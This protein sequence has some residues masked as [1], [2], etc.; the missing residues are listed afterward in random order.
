M[1][2]DLPVILVTGATGKLGTLVIEKLLKTVPAG[3]IVAGVRDTAAAAA[4]AARGVHVRVLD[5]DR[6]ETLDAAFAGVDRVLL[7]SSNAVD[8]RL[9]QHVNVVV[10]AART[11]VSLLAYTSIL[12]ADTSPLL[13]A[14][15]H[16]ATEAALRDSG[17]PFVL[18]RNGWYIENITG[19][20]AQDLERGVRFGCAGAGAGRVSAATRADYAEAAAAVLSAANQAGRIYDLAGDSAFTMADY[21]A[22]LSRQSGRPVSYRDMPQAEFRQAL[23]RAGRPEALA[24]AIADADAGASC[25]ALFD[26]GGQLRALIGRPTTT[27][28][29]VV[30]DQIGVALREHCG[31]TSS[32]R[33]MVP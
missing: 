29:R 12:H 10:A 33:G 32:A 15:E 19:F 13:L 22:E 5:Y 28:A 21:V 20:A 8:R 30:A 31:W 27:L 9:R 23:I 1:R 6:P 17:L 24:T 4:H 18:L 25:G 16:R 26:K 3:C 7:I 2:S 14:E 11:D